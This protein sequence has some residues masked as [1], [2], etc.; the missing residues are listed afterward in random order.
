MANFAITG[1]YQMSPCRRTD[2]WEE[3]CVFSVVTNVKLSTNIRLVTMPSTGFAFLSVC[4]KG[5]NKG[6]K[7]KKK[8][9]L[10]C[11]VVPSLDESQN[12]T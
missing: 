3:Y 1:I 5:D 8:T 9:K 11:D 4:Q 6:T 10:A 12:V 2:R 7:N